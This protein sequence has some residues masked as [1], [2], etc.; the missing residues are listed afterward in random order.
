MSKDSFQEWTN[1][2]RAAEHEKGNFISKKQAYEMHKDYLVKSDA[3]REKQ[4]RQIMK[5]STRFYTVHG[6]DPWGDE[7]EGE[8]GNIEYEVY[9][10][11]DQEEG[12]E[13]ITSDSKVQDWELSEGDIIE[14]D[15]IRRERKNIVKRLQQKFK[16]ATP[17]KDEII[18]FIKHL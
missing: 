11:V 12:M 10:E 1:R 14:R 13:P 9:E 17:T 2:I 8:G 7:N 16:N 5:Y 6:S 4:R 3:Q 18:E 15:T